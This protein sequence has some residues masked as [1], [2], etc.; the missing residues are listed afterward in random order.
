MKVSESEAHAQNGAYF[1]YL[2]A[3]SES[4][5]FIKPRPTVSLIILEYPGKV[6]QLFVFT[7]DIEQ[8]KTEN[9]AMM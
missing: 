5:G 6:G 9:R 7:P 3:A 8:K 1:I 2:G 4:S